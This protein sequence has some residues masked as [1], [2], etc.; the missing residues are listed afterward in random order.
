M[1]RSKLRA[2]L[3]DLLY[4]ISSMDGVARRT[5]REA[6]TLSNIFLVDLNEVNHFITYIFKIERIHT[7]YNIRTEIYHTIK[8][9]QNEENQPK[10]NLIHS[11]PSYFRTER[12]RANLK[13]VS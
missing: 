10:L 7:R 8:Q 5:K 4:S 9:I 2:R 6:E 12:S 1:T 11:E 3:D 13:L